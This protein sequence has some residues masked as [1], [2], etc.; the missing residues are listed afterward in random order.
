MFVQIS[1]TTGNKKQAEEIARRLVKAHLAACVQ[2]IGPIES[3]YRWKGKIEST[4]EWLCLIKAKGLNFKKIEKEIKR[5]HSYEVPEI[6]AIP[7]IKGS[8]EYLSW[9]EGD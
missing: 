5:L 7:I 1:T 4:K 3:V 6:V 8:G 2:V 9:M